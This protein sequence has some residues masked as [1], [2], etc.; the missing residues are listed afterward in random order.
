M[1]TQTAAADLVLC[2]I[3]GGASALLTQPLFHGGLA[4]VESGFARQRL[5]D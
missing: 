1:L 3:S 5:R 2:L 4:A